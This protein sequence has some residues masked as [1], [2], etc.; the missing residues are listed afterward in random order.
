[1]TKLLYPGIAATSVVVESPTVESGSSLE[2]PVFESESKS[3]S[4]KKCPSRVRVESPLPEF[5]SESSLESPVF[6]SESSHQGEPTEVPS[7]ND[8]LQR[9]EDIWNQAHTH[10][11]HAV[12]R[13]KSQASRHRRPNPEYTPGQWI[14]LS[15]RDLRLRLSVTNE[16]PTVPPAHHQREPSP[17]Y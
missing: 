17:E 2:S 14:W 9:S 11:L 5:E 15:T 3:E 1:M 8:W 4:P 6:E 13:Q 16:T 10:L 12:R 7:V